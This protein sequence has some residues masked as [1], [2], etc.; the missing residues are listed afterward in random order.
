MNGMTNRG[1]GVRLLR[2]PRGPR[3]KTVV[4]AAIAAAAVAAGG[5]TGGILA[6]QSSDTAGC[7]RLAAWW[8]STGHGEAA[9]LTKDL[10]A[11]SAAFDNDTLTTAWT[12]LGSDASTMTG[13]QEGNSAPA[14]SPA[15][16]FTQRW[17]G[18]LIGYQTA[19][20]LASTQILSEA[21][22]NLAASTRDL[23]ACGVDP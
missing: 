17:A 15:N 7:A 8:K 16:D 12:Q 20:S 11:L 22:G 3:R 9:T 10:S 5:I 6:A 14:G 1:D 13:Y 2:R 21:S 19:A 4:I 23:Q 18:I